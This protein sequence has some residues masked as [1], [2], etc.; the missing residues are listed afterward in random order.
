MNK[1]ESYFYESNVGG[2]GAVRGGAGA[3][4]NKHDFLVKNFSVATF[5]ENCEKSENYFSGQGF[6]CK[7][8]CRNIFTFRETFTRKLRSKYKK[9]IH[10]LLL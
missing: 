3:V 5:C 6:T 10:F 8:S 7:S 4:E 1:D 9:G 2:N